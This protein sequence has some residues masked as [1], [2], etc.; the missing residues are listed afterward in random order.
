MART[1]TA[2]SRRPARIADEIKTELRCILHD[3]C[4]LVRPI[5]HFYA[6]PERPVG[7]PR[8]FVCFDRSAHH[9]VLGLRRTILSLTLPVESITELAA[10]T[11][12]SVW[13][14]KDRLNHFAK[15]TGSATDSNAWANANINTQICGDIGNR[16]KHGH[17]QNFSGLNPRLADEVV[18]DTSKSGVV[19]LYFDG[20]TKHRELL[21]TN[22]VPIPFR[23][24]VLDG[25]NAVLGNVT[26]IIR[27]GFD[28]W[29]P[30]IDQLGIL[31]GTQRDDMAL[32]DVL[33]PRS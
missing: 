29:L 28:H 24:Q 25:A 32:R 17:N 21:V 11:A 8:H 1:R 3:L 7:V 18:F 14:L 23:V 20:A 2:S 22:P 6:S 12:A 16:K 30:L 31:S 27:V 5:G 15:A 33:F 26:D 9:E 13:H 10:L 19:E 4:E